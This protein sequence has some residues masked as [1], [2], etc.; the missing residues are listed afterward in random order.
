LT[1][2]SL[3]PSR[4]FR[5][6]ALAF[7]LIP[8]LNASAGTDLQPLR[9]QF[10][11][12]S[13]QA[14]LPVL[15]RQVES[16]RAMELKAAEARDYDTALAAR[17]ERRKLSATL[18]D[19]E[20]MELLVEAQSAV[21]GRKETQ[22]IVLNPAEAKLSGVE[23]EAKAL[24]HWSGI[25]ASATWK[26]PDL[27]P[28]GYEVILKYECDSAGKDGM[29]VQEKFFTLS[30]EWQTSAKG[31]VEHRLG[32]LRVRDGG[33]LFKV[34]AKTDLQGKLLKLQSVELVPVTHSS[35]D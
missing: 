32:I 26:L 16:L 33:G 14:G 3:A 11:H 6:F 10:E 25:D 4:L 18:A 12:D 7:L 28:G 2:L 29:M 34:V 1:S 13:L 15:R 9:K 27:A 24:T 35:D 23:L 20:K 19:Q 30:G 5:R 31:P 21:V 22:R 17:A 8:W